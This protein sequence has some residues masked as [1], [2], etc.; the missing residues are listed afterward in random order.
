M[1][2]ALALSLLALAVRLPSLDTFFTADE[3]LWVDRS[4]NFLG[5][6]LSSE[7]ECLLPYEDQT[8]VLP[9]RG[10]ACTL[11]TGHPGVVTMWS[12]SLGI[13]LQWLARP[14]EDGRSLLDFVEQLPTNPVQQ[15]TIAPVRLPTVILTS[16]FVGGFYLLLCC[17]FRADIALLAG[18][19]LALNPFHIALSRVLHHDALSTG[20]IITSALALMLYFGVDRRRRWLLLAGTLAGFALLTKSTGFFL[21]PYAGLLALWSM[22]ARWSRGEGPLSRLFGQTVVDGLLWAVVAVL[23]FSLFWPAMWVIPAEALRAIFVIGFKYASGGHAKGVLFWGN[24]SRDPGP[25]FYPVTWLFRT[26]PWSLAG[27]LI[28]AVLSIGA[29]RRRSG[30]QPGLQGWLDRFSPRG[31]NDKTGLLL[32]VSA[33]LF[34]FMLA[35]IMGEKKQDRYVLPIYPM[36]DIIA[37]AGLFSLVM[38]T[39]A[40]RLV[41]AGVLVINLLLIVPRAPYYFNY[42]NPLLGGIKAAA[43]TMTIGWGEGLNLA[44]AYLNAKPNADTLRVA[45]W[46]GSTFAPFFEGETIRYS[47]QK[48][49]ALGGEYVVF[50]VNQLQRQF[51]DPEIWRYFNENFS[52]E[53]TI[54]LDGVPYAWIFTG[55]AIGHYVED[56]RYQGI[57]SLLGWDWRGTFNP[58][59]GPVPAGS[60]LEYALF[61]EYLGKSPEEEF[62]FRLIGGDGRVWV[63]G[64]SHPTTQYAG[65]AAWQEGQIIEERGTLPLPP[66]LP[67]GVYELQIGFYTAAP[68]VVSGELTFPTA[69]QPLD[70]PLQTIEVS[71][72]PEMSVAG[73]TGLLD[74]ILLTPAFKGLSAIEKALAFDLTWSLS[75]ATKHDYQA[76]LALVDGEGEVRW[77]WESRPLVEFLP[78]S[79]WPVSRHVRT[80]WALPLETR[81]PG[82]SFQLQ[83]RLEDE[84]GQAVEHSL[85]RVTLPGRVRNFTRPQPQQP[86]EAVFAESIALRGLDLSADSLASGRQLGVTLYWQALAPLP[87]DYTVFLQLLGP[88]GQVIAQQDKAPLD[89]NALTSTWTPGEVISDT[90]TLTLPQSL[91]AGTYRLISGFYLLDTG[92]RLAVTEG[93]DFVVLYEWPG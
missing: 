8:N 90:F 91:P 39:I 73:G 30:G 18:L 37:A 9:G 6:L 19:L 40:R 80:R 79:K 65:I 1:L 75:Q 29:L 87:D 88:E 46:Y 28:A 54:S 34:F 35:M 15:A 50:Y 25:L 7:F 82:G 86:L 27:A 69:I 81:T 89:G 22:L 67:P 53:Q 41:L 24:V 57:A 70:G 42:Y 58:D 71:A 13:G 48:G 11:R 63:E 49:N 23:T 56:Q 83:L 33:F 45:S 38:G 92:R 55:P 76:A 72:G 78:T 84:T 68:A 5:G 14:A 52:L 77:E 60:E 17:L 36:L 16:L 74:L 10:L 62:F 47:D 93:G 51:P 85:G 4:R 2:I 12:G 20:F 43:Q 32:W 59:E 61:W 31:F 44:A 64:T 26:N 3:F 21:I 66:D